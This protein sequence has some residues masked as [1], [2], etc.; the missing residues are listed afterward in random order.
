M[1]IC[2]PPTC[3]SGK[4]LGNEKI[5]AISPVRSPCET[6]IP[7][8]LPCRNSCCRDR[9]DSFVSKR[10]S[11][12]AD[13][14]KRSRKHEN[15]HPRSLG[16][17]VNPKYRLDSFVSKRSRVSVFMLSRSLGFCNFQTFPNICGSYNGWYIFRDNCL[18]LF[19]PNTPTP[20][21]FP[22]QYLKRQDYYTRI[23]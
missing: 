13:Q 20:R 1:V 17:S 22:H 18:C 2:P 19:L 11:T 3:A 21:P 12:F 6:A 5:Q 10:K 4:S 9:L 23:D 7:S 15:Q 8:E 16:I 14:S